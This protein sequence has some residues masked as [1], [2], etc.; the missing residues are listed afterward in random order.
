MKYCEGDKV[1]IRKNYRLRNRSDA[2]KDIYEQRIM[3]LENR[4]AIITACFETCSYDRHEPGY[5]FKE[6][7]RLIF[8]ESM[9]ECLI[10]GQGIGTRFEILDL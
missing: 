7:P 1:R 5:R 2:F 10:D 9:I 8:K 3:K 4:T 6:F